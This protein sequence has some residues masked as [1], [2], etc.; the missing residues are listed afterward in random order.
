MFLNLASVSFC[1]KMI[2]LNVLKKCFIKSGHQTICGP[3]NFP[4]WSARKK[5]LSNFVK[6]NNCMQ[7]FFQIVY[8][9]IKCKNLFL[10][11]T[12]LLCVLWFYFILYVL[13]I[14]MLYMHWWR[15]NKSFKNKNKNKKY[16]LL[17]I[18][19]SWSAELF[20]QILWYA[21]ILFNILSFTSSKT[22][23]ML[24]QWCYIGKFVTRHHFSFL[25]SLF[26]SKV[27]I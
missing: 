25:L 5:N 15:N 24:K 22:W 26:S 2:T 13:S 18:S 3:P 16:I 11:R 20:C 4:I 9:K 1:H 14:I 27:T 17:Q 10:S 6:N 12:V 19:V 7:H 23:D 8:Y 21:N